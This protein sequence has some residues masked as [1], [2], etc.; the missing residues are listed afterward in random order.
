M[1]NDVTFLVRLGDHEAAERLTDKGVL[2][3]CPW[4]GRERIAITFFAYGSDDT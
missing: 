4:C 3:P 1:M 2:L